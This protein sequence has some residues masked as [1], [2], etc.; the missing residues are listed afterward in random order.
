MFT[1]GD[2]LTF[3]ILLGPQV[4][5]EQPLLRLREDVPARK[6]TIPQALT[7][8]SLL[9]PHTLSLHLQETRSQ[10][11]Y[12]RHPIMKLNYPSE[13]A[14]LCDPAGMYWMSLSQALCAVQLR[15]DITVL[16]LCFLC[17]FYKFPMSVLKEPASRMG[18]WKINFFSASIFFV[19]PGDLWWFERSLG[20]WPEVNCV[21]RGEDR[22]KSWR[23]GVC[24]ESGWESVIPGTC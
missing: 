1:A 12:K 16:I 4:A 13:H 19:A 8:N 17:S 3:Q 9:L 7:F 14:G 24:S 5:S 15:A 18:K 20:T 23:T 6:G 2:D 22:A 21:D 10:R 11:F